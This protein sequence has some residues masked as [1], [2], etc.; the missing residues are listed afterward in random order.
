MQILPGEQAELLKGTMVTTVVGADAVVAAQVSSI[1]RR[2]LGSLLPYFA[3]RPPLLCPCTK[4]FVTRP[5][6]MDCCAEGGG[7]GRRRRRRRRRR[8]VHQNHEAEAGAGRS[9]AVVGAQHRQ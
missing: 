7:G 2:W 8:G 5:A 9:G 1:C 3:G 4:R 6:H